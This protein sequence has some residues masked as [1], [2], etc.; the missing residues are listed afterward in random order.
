MDYTAKENTKSTEHLKKI[1]ESLCDLGT[2]NDFLD[3]KNNVCRWNHTFNFYFIF[4]F[5]IVV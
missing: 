2:D 4:T 5:F 3:G 1:G